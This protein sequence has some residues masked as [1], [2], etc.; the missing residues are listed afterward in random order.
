MVYFEILGT[1]QGGTL[2]VQGGTLHVLHVKEETILLR[3]RSFMPIRSALCASLMILSLSSPLFAFPPQSVELLPGYKLPDSAS[4]GSSAVQLRYFLYFPS[5]RLAAGIG[6]GY[7]S[8]EANHPNLEVGSNLET[9]PLSLAVK[10]LLPSSPSWIPY[11]EFGIDRLSKLRYQLDP[12]IDTRATI[13]CDPQFPGACVRRRFKERSFGYH[14][15]AGLERVFDSGLGL[16]FHY[17]F[18]AARPLERTVEQTD[19]SG[20][21]PF[22]TL[23]DDV[24]KINTSILSFLISYHFN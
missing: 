8:A 4:F 20:I 1:E 23:K 12:S 9:Q 18:L 7:I 21:N 6:T 17:M 19:A 15:G 5:W 13:G 2:H 22:S 24:F 11:F 14:V 3:R 10:L 16:G